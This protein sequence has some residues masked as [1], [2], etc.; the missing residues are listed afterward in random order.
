MIKNSTVRKT[1][2]SHYHCVCQGKVEFQPDTVN[3]PLFPEDVTKEK[4]KNISLTFFI[5]K[6]KKSY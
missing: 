4:E 6:H 5:W 3:Q 1:H 2:L